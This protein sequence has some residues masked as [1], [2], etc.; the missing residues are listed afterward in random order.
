MKNGGSKTKTKKMLVLFF[1]KS[2]KH[3]IRVRNCF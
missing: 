3:E 1:A 2:R